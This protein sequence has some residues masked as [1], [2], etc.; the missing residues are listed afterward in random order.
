MHSRFDQYFKYLHISTAGDKR[1][2]EAN[3]IFQNLHEK[4]P[5]DVR[6]KGQT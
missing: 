4:I 3:R 5:I 2:D 6:P 1:F